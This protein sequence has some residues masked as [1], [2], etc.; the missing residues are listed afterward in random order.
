[1]AKNVGPATR[2]D[3][4]RRKMGNVR[5][6]VSCGTY[7]LAGIHRAAACGAFKLGRYD[8]ATGQDD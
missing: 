4:L 1:V 2:S 8:G 6:L 7:N 5:D 3:E